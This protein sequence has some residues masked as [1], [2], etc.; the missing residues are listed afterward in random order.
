MLPCLILRRDSFDFEMS[1]RALGF[2]VTEI[3]W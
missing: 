1:F 3:Y 2:R